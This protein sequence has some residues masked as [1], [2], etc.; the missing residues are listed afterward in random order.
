MHDIYP[1][2]AAAD[3]SRLVPTFLGAFP[4]MDAADQQ[5]GLTLYRSLAEGEPVSLS[6]LAA[7]AGRDADEVRATLGD[8]SGIF[9]DRSDRICGYW[10]LSV[11]ETRH[12]LEVNGR[13]LYAWCA[14]DTLFL[15]QLLDA[16]AHIVSPCPGTGQAIEL[17]VSP[18]GIESAP[19]E[20]MVSFLAPEPTA[21]RTDVTVSFCCHVHFLRNPEAAKEWI[22][23]HRGS[24]AVSLQQAFAFGQALNQHRFEDV[25]RTRPESP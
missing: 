15:P 22:D 21:V 4:V 11:N 6:G 14:W 16:T 3:W 1:A 2:S 20:V 18:K 13:T 12:R 19:D 25:L 8:W 7:K 5:L 9:F 23:A 17:C 24:F 10:G